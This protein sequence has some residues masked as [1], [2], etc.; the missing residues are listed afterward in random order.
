[1]IQTT[2]NDVRLLLAAVIFLVLPRPAFAI[3]GEP[4]V[5]FEHEHGAFVLSASGRSAPLCANSND[6]PGVLRILKVFQNDIATVTGARPEISLDRLPSSSNIVIIG[7]LGRSPLIDTLTQKNKVDVRAIAGAWESFLVQSVD[8]PFPGVDRAL[9]I[10]GS[11]KRGTMYGMFAMSEQIGVSSAPRRP[12][13]MMLS[14][15][16]LRLI[17]SR[18]KASRVCGCFA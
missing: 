9:V 3:G 7:T 8:R 12:I 15:F 10:V 6:H 17:P 18:Q 4:Y 11:D 2:R 14:K 1:M 16:L 13:V 5:R